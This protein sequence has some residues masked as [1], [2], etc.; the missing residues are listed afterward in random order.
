MKQPRY[1]KNASGGLVTAEG[2]REA[3]LSRGSEARQSIAKADGLQDGGKCEAAFS[4]SPFIGK[5]RPLYPAGA[6]LR[7][8]TTFCLCSTVRTS[9]QPNESFP[10]YRGAS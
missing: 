8:A 7:S 1:N 2:I 5:M 3:T 4:L 6:V 10:D 9:N